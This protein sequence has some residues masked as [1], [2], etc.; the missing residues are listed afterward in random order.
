MIN[1]FFI[2][3]IALASIIDPTKIN[4]IN[5]AKTE[6]RNAYLSGDYKTA[7]KKYK[8][9]TDSL[10]VKEDEVLFNLGNAYFLEK[11]TA[12]AMSTFQLLTESPQADISSKAHQQL[13]VM[14]NQKG[15][16]DQALSD[17]KQAIKADPTNESARY[18]YEMLKKKLDEK[19]KQDQKNQKDKNDKDNPQ[20]KKQEPSAFAKRL[21]QKADELVS[22]REYKSAHDLMTDGLKKDPSVS[23]YDDY[24][25]RIKDIVD[26]NR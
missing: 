22:Q 11:D 5:A 6:A 16:F 1:L 19:K 13:G 3:L 20:D 9:L 21:K 12:N 10:A 23:Y 8:F 18:N 14:A 15:K 24:I 4:R 26:I 17:F 25:K 7:I 2:S